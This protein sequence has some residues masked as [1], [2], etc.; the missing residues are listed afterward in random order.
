MQV[1]VTEMHVRVVHIC[2]GTLMAFIP[3]RMVLLHPSSR[4]DRCRTRAG[5]VHPQCLS[6]WTH[7]AGQPTASA[8]AVSLD[9]SEYQSR[10]RRDSRATLI[11]LILHL[12]FKQSPSCKISVFGSPESFRA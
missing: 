3:I 11:S 12:V 9:V 8:A 2:L 5:H 6:S 7:R 4:D 1:V 10:V